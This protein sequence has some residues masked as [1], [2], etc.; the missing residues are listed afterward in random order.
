M[1]AVRGAVAAFSGAPAVSL[2][3]WAPSLRLPHQFEDLFNAI[4]LGEAD[5]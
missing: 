4:A 1:R 3:R 2:S 5:R